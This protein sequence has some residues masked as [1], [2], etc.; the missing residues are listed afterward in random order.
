MPPSRIVIDTCVAR[1][2]SGDSDNDLAL[3]CMK[4]LESLRQHGHSVVLNKPIHC[5]WQK[6]AKGRPADS[7]PYHASRHALQW[8]TDMQSHR[9]LVFVEYCQHPDLL[10]ELVASACPAAAGE[11]SKDF[12]IVDAALATDGRIISTDSR[13][14]NMLAGMTEQHPMLDTIIWVH[15]MKDRACC[16]LAEGAPDRPELHIGAAPPDQGS[17]M[18]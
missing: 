11:I 6:Q 10:D 13:M 7:W 15:V 4:T 1:S 14:H 2:A 12:P 17:A 18:P 8:L 16:W 5:E 9:R 3:A